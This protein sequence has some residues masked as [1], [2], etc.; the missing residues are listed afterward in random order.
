[1]HNLK[2]GDISCKQ[3][4]WIEY[5]LPFTVYDKIKPTFTFTSST[6][7]TLLSSGRYALSSCAVW[8]HGSWTAV[9]RLTPEIA[10]QLHLLLHTFQKNTHILVFRFSPIC[11][12]KIVFQ[13]HFQICWKIQ[14]TKHLNT[15]L[16]TN[17]KWQ[18]ER[19][20][21]SECT[22][23]LECVCVCVC[24]PNFTIATN[25]YNLLFRLKSSF[26]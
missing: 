5:K 23:V 26:F 6:S 4:F 1:M 7:G 9:W 17:C 22:S 18:M 8:N 13:L 10:C 12:T 3:K 21:Y 19:P 14:M 16:F 2:I 24:V 25:P 15:C 20:W 11:K